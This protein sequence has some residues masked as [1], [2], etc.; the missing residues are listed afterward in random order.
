[1]C[2]PVTRWA[3]HCDASRRKWNLAIWEPL[4]NFPFFVW[5]VSQAKCLCLW[6]EFFFFFFKAH[7]QQ[8]SIQPSVCM[9]DVHH[10]PHTTST[11]EEGSV[12]WT[13]YYLAACVIDTKVVVMNVLFFYAFVAMQT[14][15][16]NSCS[17]LVS[18][19]STLRNLC[20]LPWLSSWHNLDIHGHQRMNLYNFFSSS[21]TTIVDFKWNISAAVGHSYS[22]IKW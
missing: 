5:R 2:L 15:W 6:L 3:H 1:M 13:V 17:L 14:P 10:Q 7:T 20:S 8:P 18:L 9:S 19:W 4:L 12:C 22:I 21:M 16:E 11:E